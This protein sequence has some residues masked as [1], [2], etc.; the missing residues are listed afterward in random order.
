MSRDLEKAEREVKEFHEYKSKKEE[1]Y[2]IT[3][4]LKNNPLSIFRE[5]MC[6]KKIKE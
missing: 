6:I 5:K 3:N 4:I 1:R 2:K